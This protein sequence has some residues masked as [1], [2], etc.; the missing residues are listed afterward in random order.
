[1]EDLLLY[2]TIAKDGD[3]VMTKV[4]NESV[5]RELLTPDETWMNC[6]A[7]LLNN[8]MKSVLHHH[9]GSNELQ[10]VVDDFR[11]MKRIIEDVAKRD[12]H[13]VSG[14]SNTTTDLAD[15]LKPCAIFAPCQRSSG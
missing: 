8:T 12:P 2:F 14:H 7:H 6:M 13:S 4:A 1:M 3:A 9:C 5:S 10:V 15:L 11:S